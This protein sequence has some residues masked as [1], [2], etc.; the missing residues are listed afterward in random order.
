MGMQSII[1][2]MLGS[3]GQERTM[4]LGRQN[5]RLEDAGRYYL[6]PAYDKVAAV[7][8]ILGMM[9][10]AA[11]MVDMQQSSADLMASR[12][13][14][15]AARNLGWLGASTLA[16][17]LPGNVGAVRQ[18][19]EEATQAAPKG[20]RGFHGGPHNFK[21]ERLVEWPD[22]R[23]E[24]IEGLPDVLPD[25]PQGAR[26]LQEFPLGRFR[27]DKIGTGEGA[28]AYGHGV[29]Y[30]ASNEDVAKNYRDALAPSEKRYE[31]NG[32]PIEWGMISPSDQLALKATTEP[33][34]YGLDGIV[35]R[36]ARKGM[37][38]DRV[39]ALKASLEKFKGATMTEHQPGHMYEVNINASPDDFLDWDK[40]L[41]YQPK[42][43]K[44]LG[45]SDEQIAA[46][47]K[48]Q[49]DWD[50]AMLR[51][52]EGG[53]AEAEQERAARMALKPFEA[54]GIF[55]RPEEIPGI[56]GAAVSDQMRQAGIPGIRYLDQGSRGAGDGSRNYV[57]FDES[58]ISILRKYGLAGLLAGGGAAMGSIYGSDQ[59]NSM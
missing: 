58:L 36:M 45:H 48:A 42:A 33:E 5:K 54:S 18:A 55:R 39:D 25:V 49:D 43:A 15:D 22:G 38:P 17:A 6:G 28:A 44:A 31:L 24:F 19:A 50:N 23:R 1:D 16:M 26:S 37:P 9:T 30:I 11:D 27:E 35:E 46:A 32:Q 21:A 56:K 3:T 40:S 52:L 4:W 59:G 12:T 51:A 8:K 2:A 34:A 14:G 13:P 57:V 20:I 29:A 47:T 7:P 41:L 53:P 10:P